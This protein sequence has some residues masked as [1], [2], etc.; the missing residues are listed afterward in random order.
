MEEEKSVLTNCNAEEKSD[1]YER[2]GPNAENLH[3]L[4]GLTHIC[5]F[6]MACSS[7]QSEKRRGPVQ[8]LIEQH[9]HPKD[10]H[11]SDKTGFLIAVSAA[12]LPSLSFPPCTLCSPSTSFL[13]LS[14]PVP[15]VALSTGATIVEHNK[16]SRCPWRGNKDNRFEP[17][18]FPVDLTLLPAGKWSV[19]SFFS[20]FFIIIFSCLPCFCFSSLLILLV[21]LL[22]L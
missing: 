1:E 4:E 16:G 7:K 18:R 19:F 6:L 8:G 13:L 21:L 11:E 22:F 14:R 20:R 5:M 10:T 17:L 15:A 2:V 3:H 9:T 12:Q